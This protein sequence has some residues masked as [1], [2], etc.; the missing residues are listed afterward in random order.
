LTAADQR[1]GPLGD[2]DADVVAGQVALLHRAAAA[3]EGEDAHLRVM[4]A[5][6]P[7]DRV[8]A[9]DADAGRGVAGEVAF[10]H[11]PLAPLRGQEAEQLAVV[12]RAAPDQRAA[13]G[14]A[15]DPRLGVAENLALL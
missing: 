8:A 5:A 14:A 11:G 3:Q 6:V 15:V 1:V 4:N 12:D 7:D 2:Q 13:P 9:G 10:L